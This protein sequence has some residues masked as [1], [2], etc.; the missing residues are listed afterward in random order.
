MATKTPLKAIRLKCLDC[1]C[2]SSNE[3][4]LCPIPT[5][6]LFEYRFGH[7][8]GWVSPSERKKNDEDPDEAE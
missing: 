2:G 4:K 5:C 6:P 3:V 1:M 8:P 7:R